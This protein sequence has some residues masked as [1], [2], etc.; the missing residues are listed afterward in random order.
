MPAAGFR[1]T[2]RP[3]LLRSPRFAACAF[4][5]VLSTLAACGDDDA[6]VPDGAVGCAAHSD[7]DDGLFCNGVEQCLPGDPAADPMGCVSGTTSW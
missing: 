2:L 5:L 7:C 4:A 3:I 1:E 6:V